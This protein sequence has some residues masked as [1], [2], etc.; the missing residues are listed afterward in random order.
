MIQERDGGTDLT[1]FAGL[2]DRPEAF[3][4]RLLAAVV[5]ST[6]QE[7]LLAVPEYTK[8]PRTLTLLEAE[9]YIFLELYYDHSTPQ[10]ERKTSL[11][12]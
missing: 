1:C 2:A 11:L 3:P 5:V 7:L 12:P 4:F 10:Q 8:Y 9:L 6:D